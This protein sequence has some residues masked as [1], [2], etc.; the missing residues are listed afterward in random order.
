MS[1]LS[2]FGKWPGSL[3]GDSTLGARPL[4]AEGLGARGILLHESRYGWALVTCNLALVDNICELILAY[5]VYR[6][7]EWHMFAQVFDSLSSVWR[8]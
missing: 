3:S 8:V 6:R 1:I 2:G 5:E 4:S 7:R